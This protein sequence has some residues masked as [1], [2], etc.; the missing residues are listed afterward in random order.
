[1]SNLFGGLPRPLTVLVP[2]YD[3]MN[4]FDAT[5]PIEI[6]SQANRL[7]LE[8]Q[9]EITIAAATQ[10]VTSIEGV[11][12]QVT[13]SLEDSLKKVD[14]YDILLLPGGV[15]ASISHLIAQG[16]ERCELLRLIDDFMKHD[17]KLTLSICTGSLFLAA[18]GSL[19]GR[20]ATSHWRSLPTLH[21]LSS[22]HDAPRT[23]I[24]RARYID[25]PRGEAPYLGR[26]ITAGGVACGLDATFYLLK[27]LVSAELVEKV[28]ANLDYT[29]RDA[30]EQSWALDEHTSL[31]STK[32]L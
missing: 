5:G 18:N 15:Q 13:T 9:F 2:V 24:L 27:L 1:M 14:Y 22:E 31:R 3:N 32:L 8:P 16:T 11:Q 10:S 19:R 25:S 30:E 6:L 17:C 4:I 21:K 29:Y 20:R 28:A 23:E 7:S 26:T 12:L